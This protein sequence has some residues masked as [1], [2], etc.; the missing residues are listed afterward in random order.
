MKTLLISLILLFPVIIHAQSVCDT[1]TYVWKHETGTQL[2]LA[3]KHDVMDRP[4]F[5]TSNQNN[6]MGVYK[7][8]TGTS[9]TFMFSIPIDSFNGLYV[10]NMNQYGNYMYLSLGTFFTASTEPGLAIV[11]LTDPENP[12]VMDVWQNDTIMNGSTHVTVAGDYAYLSAMEE[13]VIILDISDKNNITQVSRIQPD[14]YFPRKN[15]AA[16]QIPNARCTYYRNDTLLVCYD[17]GGLRVLDVSNKSNPKQVAQYIHDLDTFYPQAYNN[18]EVHENV[19]YVAVD[20]CG[21]I[22]LDISDMSSISLLDWW[23]PWECH[24]LKNVWTNSPGYTNHVQYL[25]DE[26]LVFLSGGPIQAIMIDASD[27]TALD[28]CT[29]FGSRA[30]TQ[31]TWG[32]SVYGNRMYLAYVFSLFPY[33]G[34]TSAVRIYEWN[35][36]SSI[37]EIH[38]PNTLSI[39]PNP[40][41]NKVFIESEQE[42]G[43]LEV[44]DM[45]G[46]LVRQITFNSGEVELDVGEWR[47]GVYLLKIGSDVGKVVVE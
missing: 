43:I 32:G 20:Y 25:P 23:N 22:S 10:T 3:V 1:P 33:Q 28:S 19:G 24:T 2:M 11:D 30:D 13:G 21:L 6:G 9:T 42:N 31:S 26:E 47:R 46:R 38:Q 29:G 8:T 16:A 15:P 5:Y 18:I 14:W 44:F 45:Q 27:P 40:A 37:S 7:H 4:Y 39:Y 12:V 36:P 34:L 17:A 41:S 35:K